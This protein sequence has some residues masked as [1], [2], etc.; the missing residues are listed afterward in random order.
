MDQELDT[1][2]ERVREL[3]ALARRLAQDNER[4]RADMEH[5]HA[6]QARLRAELVAEIDARGA[7]HGRMAQARSKVE[8]ALSRLPAPE[9]QAQAEAQDGGL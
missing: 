6:G 1:L 3:M 5:L 9:A 7:L 2:A 8:S 4:L